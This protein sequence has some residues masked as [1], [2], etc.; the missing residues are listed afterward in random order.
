M[1][2]CERCGAPIENDSAP[3]PTCKLAPVSEP[4]CRKCGTRLEYFE[5]WGAFGAAAVI[6]TILFLMGTSCVVCRAT[7]G[8]SPVLGVLLLLIGGGIVAGRLHR[9]PTLR[10]PRCRGTRRLTPVVPKE[11]P[12]GPD[13]DDR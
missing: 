12:G 2:Q 7:S 8:N 4:P 9:I 10:C 1:H 6:G 13:D 3:C 5:T 11:P